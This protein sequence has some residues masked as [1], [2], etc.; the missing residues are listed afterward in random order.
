MNRV[1]KV[2]AVMAGLLLMTAGSQAF[3]VCTQSDNVFPIFQC[4]FVGWFAPAPAG[5]GTVS[6]VW[7]Q[8][9]YGNNGVATGDAGA[10]QGTGIGPVGSF[11]GNDN[12]SSALVLTPANSV[13]PQPG[14]PAGALCANFENSW[15]APGTDGCADNPRTS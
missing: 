10:T 4:G 1:T 5:A 3:A 8:L 11:S 6:S 2:A 13:L 15:A 9:G 12:G 7:W 14:V